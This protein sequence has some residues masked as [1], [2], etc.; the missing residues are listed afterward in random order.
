MINDVKDPRQFAEV[1][2]KGLRKTRHKYRRPLT[3]AEKKVNI[4]GMKATI[5][6]FESILAR[7]YDDITA[8]MKAD[9]I[10]KIQV[11]VKNN[12][13]KAIEK[14]S[15]KYTGE[16]AAHL[17]YVKKEMFEI[18][19]KTAATE[20]VVPTPP[21]PKSVRGAMRAEQDAVVQKVASDITTKTKRA[22]ASTA[23]VA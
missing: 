16:L 18:G 15:L 21:T 1:K 10:K 13:I 6:K 4:E 12:D 8:K 20:M 5:N 2:K 14:L 9:L 3:F 22:I 7:G 11:A 23:A 17:T 19:K